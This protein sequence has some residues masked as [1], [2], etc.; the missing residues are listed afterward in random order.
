MAVTVPAIAVVAV[1]VVAVAI[2]AISIVRPMIVAVVAVA[3]PGHLLGQPAATRASKA[4][5]RPDGPAWAAVVTRPSA[6]APSP[7]ERSDFTFI[8]HLRLFGV[9]P[10]H[11]APWGAAGVTGGDGGRF[12]RVRSQFAH[13]DATALALPLQRLTQPPRGWACASWNR[14]AK[15]R[16]YYQLSVQWST[17]LRANVGETR[18]QHGRLSA[19]TAGPLEADHVHEHLDRHDGSELAE[20]AVRQGLAVAKDMRAKATVVR[21]TPIPRMYAKA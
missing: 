18:G 11:L 5:A 3:V 8:K 9:I 13:E 2:P 10:R 21:A 16:L 14:N 20:K 1:A 17:R 4:L 19:P 12:S 6:R 7:A 15:L